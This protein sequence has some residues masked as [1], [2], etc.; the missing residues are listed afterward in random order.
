MDILVNE[1]D[2]SSNHQNNN[3]TSDRYSKKAGYNNN[4]YSARSAQQQQQDVSS[5]Y[6]YYYHRTTGPMESTHQ[7][8]NSSNHHQQQHQTTISQQVKR[9]IGCQQQML[10]P[11]NIYWQ[12]DYLASSLD[13]LACVINNCDEHQQL[14]ATTK[15]KFSS[16]NMYNNNGDDCNLTYEDY[17]DEGFAAGN[18]DSSGSSAS[19]FAGCS[20]EEDV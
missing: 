14:C 8:T 5:Y 3:Q 9:K 2:T 20:E 11:S 19:S 10:Q 7:C 13:R 15:A 18:S 4:A 12:P 6:P 1:C 17:Y 16:A